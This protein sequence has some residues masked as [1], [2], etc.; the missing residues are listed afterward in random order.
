VELNQSRW[1]A[2]V[3]AGVIVAA[4]LA[5]FANSFSVPFIFDDPLSIVDNPSIRQLWP[6]G[7]AL[8][9]PCDNR[10]VTSRPLLNFSLAINYRLGGLE[11]W[12]YHAAN[13]A[14]HLINGLLLLGILRRT[15]QSPVLRERFGEAAWGLALAIAAIWTIHPLQTE[16]VTYVIQR[17]E[18]L[19]GLFYL[20]TLYSVI[21]GSQ[22]SRR[23]WWYVF[24]VGACFLGVGCKEIVST[25]PIVVLL[26]DR[27][28]LEDS[29]RKVL[30]RRWGLY[31]GF[32]VCWGFQLLL[33]ARTGVTTLT[34][35]VGSIGMWAYARSQPG[36][37]LHYLWLSFWPHPLCLDY[38][39]PVA[40]TVGAI[41]PAMLVVGGLAAA[42]VWGLTRG[43][44]WAFLGVWFFLILSPTSSIMPLPQLAFEH[45]M[46]LPLAAVL[47][48][49]VA[50]GYLAVQRVVSR[51]WISRR[52]GVAGGMSLVATAAVVLG[53]LTVHRNQVYHSKRSIWEDTIA[54][55]PHNSRA[56]SNLGVVLTV[57]G[58]I[59]ESIEHFRTAI[60]CDPKHMIAYNNLGLALTHADRWLEAIEQY[61][62]AIDLKPNYA[63][64]HMNLG[65][66]LEH[67][68]R[69]EESVKEHQ[70]AI[71]LNP[72]SA[73]AHFNLGN[74]LARLDRLAEAMEE[75]KQ[76]LQIKPDYA[77]VH[78]NWG[79]LLL[80]Q[81]RPAEAA[82]HY[83]RAIDGDPRDPMYHSNLGGALSGLDRLPEAVEQCRE[84]I[85]IAP[86]FAQAH[87]NLCLLFVKMGKVRDAIEHGLAVVQLVPNDPP[88]NCFVATLLATHESADGGDPARAVELAE[89]ACALT[90]RR[91]LGCLDALASAYASAK[92]FDKAMSTAKEAWQKA[93][94]AGQGALAAEF[95]VRMQ[96]YRDEKPYRQPAVPPAGRQP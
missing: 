45:R 10:T 33:L 1:A 35:E 67:V 88:T 83:Q 62:R 78:N 51:G 27:T 4:G 26:Y 63:E 60:R 21:R 16:A 56:H 17:A 8:S 5:V 7:S 30:R 77:E 49:A 80:R 48:L 52:A 43:R 66:A 75:F 39:W 18:S 54:K 42:T 44:G 72:Q 41:L 29:F 31:A 90:D 91:D 28:F 14:I 58:E 23:A 22:S 92:R 57:E 13:V 71:R 6:P 46:Y 47:A 59:Q 25:A 86:N 15:F 76:S 73:G 9:P 55:S 96:L 32:C 74:S 81:G 20:L 82:E 3:G 79:N 12:G 93:E 84:A 37:I 87:L 61:H 89:R 36:V 64:A 69:L 40:S 2:V 95:H 24:A 34:E 38:E 70:E 53:F 68:G 65:L 11:V 50:G 85:R 19:A 94:A